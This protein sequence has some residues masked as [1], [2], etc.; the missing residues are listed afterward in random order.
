MKNLMTIA[1]G[2]CLLGLIMVASACFVGPREGYYDG[3]HHRY[4]HEN[5]WHECGQ[6]DEHCR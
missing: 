6:N 5:A 1:R 3:D 4:Y 2:S